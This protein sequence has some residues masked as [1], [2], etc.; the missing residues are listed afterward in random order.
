M[1]LTLLVA[2]TATATEKPKLVVL[3]LTP[4]AGVEKTLTAPLTDAITNE[5]QARGYFDVMSSRD[6][7]ALLGMERQRELLGCNDASRSCM[8]EISGALG[9]R[10][11]LSGSLARLGDAW[12][13]TLTTLDS[14]KAQPLGRAT[15]LART[16]EALRTMLPFAVAEAT[17]TPA[18]PPPSRLLPFT[19]LGVGAAASLFGIV[20]GA[21]SLSQEQQLATLLDA[22]AN[23]PGLL[24]TRD[25]YRAQLQNLETQR[26]VAVGALGAGVAAIIIGAV[27]LPA[28]GSSA[29]IAVVPTGNGLGLAGRF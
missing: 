23:T 29:A 1:L 11:I 16:L 3:E 10:F 27:L 28:D 17:S 26:W 5:L 7:Q 9:A 14:Q 19:L 8:T 4:G 15:R 2:L 18:P 12:Q 20:W 13:L 21:L 6:V 22:G 24:G 25:S